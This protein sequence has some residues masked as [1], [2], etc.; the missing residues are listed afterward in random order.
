MLWRYGFL[1]GLVKSI[2]HTNGIDVKFGDV[3]RIPMIE[4]S[5]DAAT[6]A[7]ADTILKFGTF[8]DLFGTSESATVL[9]VVREYHE[10]EDQDG[11]CDTI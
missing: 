5:T 9:T 11:L 7:F 6:K 10:V 4:D 3:K 2:G 1:D 8:S